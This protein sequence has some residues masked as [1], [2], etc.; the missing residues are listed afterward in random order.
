M[1]QLKYYEAQLER[2]GTVKTFVYV[3]FGNLHTKENMKDMWNAS[4]MPFNCTKVVYTKKL[5]SLWGSSLC[6]Y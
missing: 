2:F 1:K 6:N 5:T 3:S 4:D